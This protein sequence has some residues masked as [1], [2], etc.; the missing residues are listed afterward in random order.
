ADQ[1]MDGGARLGGY[2]GMPL[3]EDENGGPELDRPGG[4]GDIREADQRIRDG[5]VLEARAHPPARRIWIARLVS[6][7]HHD[8]LHGPNGVEAGGLG[9]LRQLDR[10]GAV[11]IPAQARVSQS[12]LHGRPPVS[13]VSDRMPRAGELVWRTVGT[14]VRPVTA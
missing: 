9:R 1:T 5:V 12:E 11:R 4:R 6:V 3:G 10:R 7:R 13:S 14:R 2:H 8:V